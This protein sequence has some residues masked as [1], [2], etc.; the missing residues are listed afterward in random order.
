MR[1]NYSGPGGFLFS[2]FPFSSFL[3]HREHDNDDD[4]SCVKMCS[5]EKTTTS[6]ELRNP[7][8]ENECLQLSE[9]KTNHPHEYTSVL[10]KWLR[11]SAS[12]GGLA[13]WITNVDEK[14]WRRAYD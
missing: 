14:A 8:Q 7:R 11:A 10:E 3:P 6:V 5:G 2:C 13:G 12:S 1:A 4:D 9:N